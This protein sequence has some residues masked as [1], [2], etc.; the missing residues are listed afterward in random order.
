MPIE[1]ILTAWK[2]AIW[3]IWENIWEWIEFVWEKVLDAADTV[4][5]KFT[6]VKQDFVNLLTTWPKKKWTPTKITDEDSEY[7]NRI[8]NNS[9]TQDVKEIWW[10]LL[11]IWFWKTKDALW[12][13][14][15]K[16]KSWIKM[17]D[18]RSQIDSKYWSMWDLQKKYQSYLDSI[19]KDARYALLNEFYSKVDSL[20]TSWMWDAEAVVTTQSM[21]SQKEL[22]E[23]SKQQKL[24]E[25]TA[26]PEIQK[27]E[28]NIKDSESSLREYVWNTIEVEEWEDPLE[29][30][31]WW[32]E[33]KFK[34]TLW[35][36]QDL[37]KKISEEVDLELSSRLKVWEWADWKI[38]LAKTDKIKEL[39]VDM[40]LQRLNALAETKEE[41]RDTIN[42]EYKKSNEVMK[43][44][45]LTQLEEEQKI[46]D[47][48]K[49]AFLDKD[50][51][52][53][54]RDAAF[55]AFYKLSEEEQ[56]IL[57][58]RK[59]FNWLMSTRVE[60]TQL[61]KSFW[62]FESSGW[63]WLRQAMDTMQVL[64]WASWIL[65]N[66]SAEWF[67][68]LTW[69]SDNLIINQLANPIVNADN[70]ILTKI[71]KYVTYN[72]WDL[73]NTMASTIAPNK[74]I[75]AATKWTTKL[76]Q[77]SLASLPNLNKATA[78]Q[79]MINWKK[80]TFMLNAAKFYGTSVATWVWPNKAIDDSLWQ[81]WTESNEQFNILTDM[82]FDSTLWVAWKWTS[83]VYTKWK[84]FVK[85]WYAESTNSYMY[86]F[87][88]GTNKEAR[89]KAVASLTEHF[90]TRKLQDWTVW[91]KI[92]W[93]PATT[94]NVWEFLRNEIIPLY[95]Q[96]VDPY[97][98]NKIF[99]KWEFVEF[100]SDHLKDLTNTWNE[101]LLTEKWIWIELVDEFRD[102]SNKLKD[103]HILA[104]N[105][106]LSSNDATK[107]FYKSALYSQLDDNLKRIEWSSFKSKIWLWTLEKVKPEDLIKYKSIIEA[108]KT[109]KP[110]TI[111]M[112]IDEYIEQTQKINELYA[113]EKYQKWIRLTD[114]ITWNWVFIKMSDFEKIKEM[115]WMSMQEM[116]KNWFIEITQDISTKTWIQQ[117]L[118]ITKQEINWYWFIKKNTRDN[119]RQAQDFAK[120]I[121]SENEVNE[122]ALQLATLIRAT[123]LWGW[124]MQWLIATPLDKFVDYDK[125]IWF[126]FER[127]QDVYWKNLI[128]ELNLWDTNIWPSWVLKAVTETDS[129]FVFAHWKIQSKDWKVINVPMYVLPWKKF[130]D[131]T[132]LYSMLE[133]IWDNIDAGR[134]SMYVEKASKI[135]REVLV[136][137][138][139][140]DWVIDIKW[141]IEKVDVLNSI[142]W[143]YYSEQWVFNMDRVKLTINKA[144]DNHNNLN[145]WNQFKNNWDIVKTIW[146]FIKH[147]D[148]DSD[149]ILDVIIKNIT[150]K[151]IANPNASKTLEKFL[152]SSLTLEK[153][154]NFMK[155]FFLSDDLISKLSSKKI[156]VD[157]DLLI[158]LVKSDK[159]K[160]IKRLQISK[161][162]LD[163]DIYAIKY[164][165][166]DMR[167]WNWDILKLRADLK[168][169]EDRLK[170]I[171]KKL[172]ITDEEYIKW[173][174]WIFR[175][176]KILNKL[177]GIAWN[178]ANKIDDDLAKY[179]DKITS[180]KDE[181]KEVKKIER[182]FKKLSDKQKLESNKILDQISKAKSKDDLKIIIKEL[183]E[184]KVDN[185]IK[186][187]VN[188]KIKLMDNIK[189][190]S[191]FRVDILKQV[192]DYAN[193]TMWVYDLNKLTWKSNPL[194]AAF[195]W[196]WAAK[197]NETWELT[198]MPLMLLESFKK[199]CWVW[200]EV[201][202]ISD[203]IDNE[204]FKSFTENFFIRKADVVW[205]W[206]FNTAYTKRHNEIKKVLKE[207]LWDAFNNIQW[208][209]DW[210][211]VN[212]ANDIIEDM[213][214]WN[215]FKKLFN[216]IKW[217]ANRIKYEMPVLKLDKNNNVIQSYWI[218]QDRVIRIDEM[219]K[220]MPDVSFI[221]I[222][223]DSPAKVISNISIS[224][225]AKPKTFKTIVKKL[226]KEDYLTDDDVLKVAINILNDAWWELEE[227]IIKSN[228]WIKQSLNNVIWLKEWQKIVWSFWDK[229]NY[230]QVWNVPEWAIKNNDITQMLY[231]AYYGLTMWYKNSNKIIRDMKWELFSFNDLIKW[232]KELW[233]TLTTKEDFKSA[234]SK[235]KVWWKIIK[236]WEEVDAVVTDYLIQFDKI[237]KRESSWTS[238][239]Y[240][241]DDLDIKLRAYILKP[242]IDRSNWIFDLLEEY[243]KPIT[244]NYRKIQIITELRKA[245]QS[246][247]NISKFVKEEYIEWDYL[248]DSKIIWFLSQMYKDNFD[249]WAAVTKDLHDKR[250]LANWIEPWLYR[251]FKDHIKD[252]TKDNEEFFIKADFHWEKAIL[253]WAELKNS[254]FTTSE[255]LKLSWW[256]KPVSDLKLKSNIITIWWR[257]FEIE[258][259]QD[260]STRAFKDAAQE[261][262]DHT[263]EVTTAWN[264]AYNSLP[265]EYQRDLAIEIN[266]EIDDLWNKLVLDKLWKQEF[267]NTR[268]KSDIDLEVENIVSLYK[269][270]WIEQVWTFSDALLQWYVW[271]FL[272]ASTHL[273]NKNELDWVKNIIKY[274][275]E[276]LWLNEIKISSNDKLID[277]AIWEKQA[278][279]DLL[280]TM[281]QTKDILSEIKSLTKEDWVT[282][283]TDNLFILWLRHPVPS[284]Y[285][286]WVYKI[287]KDDNLVEWTLVTNPFNTYLKVEWD[288]DWDTLVMSSVYSNRWYIMWK[289]AIDPS[290]EY[291]TKPRWDFYS[292]LKSW[293]DNQYIVVSQ[294]DDIVDK[295]KKELSLLENRQVALA[296]K[297]NIGIVQ[298]FWRSL[299]LFMEYT[300]SSEL[301]KKSFTV[302]FDWK[303][304]SLFDLYNLYKIELT[305]ELSKKFDELL[306]SKIQVTLDFA[307][308][309]KSEF[310]KWWRK[311]I[312]ELVLWNQLKTLDDEWRKEL[313]D[314]FI[315]DV[316]EPLSMT[317][318][319]ND[320]IK[321]FDFLNT[322]DK[323]SMYYKNKIWIKWSAYKHIMDTYWDRI[324]TF[325]MNS[326]KDFIATFKWETK[327]VD[328]IFRLVW[329]SVSKKATEWKIDFRNAINAIW[330]L[331][332]DKYKKLF[333]LIDIA[334]D[335]LKELWDNEKYKAFENLDIDNLSRDERLL[336]S[337]Y[338]IDNKSY[339]IFNLLT[340]EEKLTHIEFAAWWKVD[341]LLKR[342]KDWREYKAIQEYKNKYAELINDKKWVKIQD[343]LSDLEELKKNYAT[344][345]KSSDSYTLDHVKIEEEIAK[346][347]KLV[348]DYNSYKENISNLIESSKQQ[349]ELKEKIN[350]EVTEQI[351]EIDWW[352][353]FDE[354]SM[355]N[356][357]NVAN[358]YK[359]ARDKTMQLSINEILAK[360]DLRLLQRLNFLT[361]QSKNVEYDWLIL[362]RANKDFWIRF[363]KLAKNI[364]FRWDQLDKLLKDIHWAF[365]EEIRLIDWK[366][367]ISDI[368]KVIKKIQDAS[369]NK[370]WTVIADILSNDDFRTLISEFKSSFIDKALYW[371]N[372]VISKTKWSRNEI[373]IENYLKKGTNTLFNDFVESLKNDYTFW[374]RTLNIM[375]KTDAMT[376]LMN[377]WMWERNASILSN[378]LYPPRI[379][380]VE[381]TIW[382]I[383]AL[384]YMMRYW[385]VWTTAMIW[386]L[387]WIAQLLPNYYQ[388]VWFVDIHWDNLKKADNIITK[389]WILNS[390]DTITHSLWYDT[391]TAASFIMDRVWSIFRKVWELATWWNIKAW[392]AVEAFIM[393]PLSF[394]DA[395]LD[396]IRKQAALID[397]LNKKWIPLDHSWFKQYLEERVSRWH[398]LQDVINDIS[399]EARDQY[400]KSWG[401]VI[402]WSQLYRKTLL[403][404]MNI[405]WDEEKNILARAV[406]WMVWYLNWW[407]F[408]NTAVLIYKY[409]SLWSWLTSLLKWDYK[410]SWLLVWDWLMY[411]KWLL[412][413]S[414]NAIW[415]FLKFE[416]YERDHE[417]IPTKQEFVNDFNN[418]L[419]SLEILMW[420]IFDDVELANKYWDEWTDWFKYSTLNLIKRYIR[421]IW[422]M[423]KLA[424][425][426]YDQYIISMEPDSSAMDKM[427]WLLTAIRDSTK[428]LNDTF[429]RFNWLE[430][431]KD[432]YDSYSSNANIWLLWLWGAT[433]EDKIYEFNMKWKNFAYFE[434]EWFAQSLLKYLQTWISPW[435]YWDTYATKKEAREILVD[436]Y[437]SE[438]WKLLTNKWISKDWSNWTYDIRNILWFDESITDDNAYAIQ[439]I[440][441]AMIYDRSDELDSKWRNI[442]NKIWDNWKKF[443][444]VKIDDIITDN[445]RRIAEE[446]WID[447][448][449]ILQEKNWNSK[450][451]QKLLALVEY[452]WEW[453]APQLI[454]YLVKSRVDEYSK[455]YKE[456]SWLRTEFWYKDLPEY[457]DNLAW[458]NSLIDYADL[459]NTDA[460]LVNKVFE[461]E[462][463]NNNKDIYSRFEKTWRTEK[464]INEVNRLAANQYIATRNLQRWDTSVWALVSKWAVTFKWFPEDSQTA[465]NIMIDTLQMIENSDQD[466]KTKVAKQAAAILWISEANYKLVQDNK[467]FESLSY[468]SKKTI[469]NWLYKISD[470]A[471]DYDSNKLTKELNWAAYWKSQY[472]KTPYIKKD[473][474]EQRPNFSKQ[475]APIEKLAQ[476]YRNYKSPDYRNMIAQQMRTTSQVVLNH[477]AIPYV[478]EVQ[479]YKSELFMNELVSKG[480][481][482]GL[483]QQLPVAKP[484]K[485]NIIEK[486][487]RKVKNPKQYLPPVKSKERVWLLRNRPFF[488]E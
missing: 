166:N 161:E 308:S 84:W 328:D 406:M 210:V 16:I 274:S 385:I 152:D 322:K 90:N 203:L 96:T 147:F 213:L 222:S 50:Y 165:I 459:L 437:K 367:D 402:S 130:F 401:W 225:W 134:F 82:F 79:S 386:Q 190:P 70:W 400:A 186:D 423:P 208:I 264:Q 105:M 331:D 232:L 29:K 356:L 292:M 174:I 28:K 136:E 245:A 236:D 248:D 487:K 65:L 220:E 396:N 205:E 383:N 460:T 144:I 6:D 145:Q 283:D 146:K 12:F 440:K 85:S 188:L 414:M 132:W 5:D 478:K 344:E 243:K 133:D 453:K 340:A 281:E 109:S 154:F 334:K 431:I 107:K 323:L 202:S 269:A 286:L 300:K 407:A 168:K 69:D 391:D 436:L 411:H 110:D 362:A 474:W 48:D 64:V 239:I 58:D 244:D 214:T 451:L 424:T 216:M 20:K 435:L 33:K 419:V 206:S 480:V 299:R 185:N 434:S 129:Y 420:Q 218:Y 275:D 354:A 306:A 363:Q 215:N 352:L 224:T 285:N 131:N 219:L 377:T 66:K 463:K 350:I 73:L 355:L 473:Y 24:Y 393:S 353:V 304:K 113:K 103:T 71:W 237:S 317:Y 238:W 246:D 394:F 484:I 111:H 251:P 253:D 56:E 462:F 155:D 167:V 320:D 428:E 223:D 34:W 433:T 198:W 339:K 343:L 15:I 333:N 40:E 458:K 77:M 432:S 204:K 141:W 125:E 481:I 221:R 315:N 139:V 233:W 91:L 256:F 106:L 102:L 467:R 409:W 118:L 27:Y 446:Q 337:I 470:T 86:D 368:S 405:Y 92:N 404:S 182:K 429:M 258:S 271:D 456:E 22:S 387:M 80:A 7:I 178:M 116:L 135:I 123:S 75:W 380:K 234:L 26:L 179:T 311:E 443:W 99:N 476:D 235:I 326:D 288:H 438:A 35:I 32:T 25:T 282:L 148:K 120:K 127:L 61:W 301:Y 330:K 1:D 162:I 369:T 193:S 3:N 95:K 196:I 450:W 270:A 486:A 349:L 59:L 47:R 472:F 68:D 452:W 422:A 45:Y 278:R 408:K 87:M 158:R 254:V 183:N 268:F 100:I 390:E 187:Y 382:F 457:Y 55:N 60:A 197:A 289:S 312:I 43:K 448:D 30:L 272:N 76:A 112:K 403:S 296:A 297:W 38:L 465:A 449:T 336:L 361:E 416:K 468:D 247:P 441:D 319:N 176:E 295:S 466:P 388:I 74:V 348:Y 327:E 347:Q 309:W 372:D 41:D 287:V 303:E 10:M 14:D 240:T 392:K 211:Q 381:K 338:A 482:K 121:V 373:N 122:K 280:K 412:N 83:N 346:M 52:K 341:K 175:N 444:T 108:V 119:Y 78:I 464:V 17:E 150:Y 485:R 37:N 46:R 277:I 291:Y 209:K 249:W 395:P 284:R 231:W 19:E 54:E 124:K 351:P 49:E 18:F 171:N 359:A 63:F 89:E 342:L 425:T 410:R 360:Y 172:S 379:Q 262:N 81:I 376:H 324:N 194:I 413:I 13:W 261:S 115:N 101:K 316:I 294:V 313:I 9:W 53:W 447:I 305:P 94:K 375:N 257:Q 259:Y 228:P 104:K 345:I 207:V 273:I 137:S 163:N 454:N 426:I 427:T 335:R 318:K 191:D 265:F 469:V 117:W 153:K 227:S 199:Y 415:L 325:V 442:S 201:R 290:T 97:I 4:S 229:S 138:K 471:Y 430:V 365:N 445:M 114:S 192:K 310:E 36:S 371:I 128:K 241:F 276:T 302:W 173:N 88:F 461:I 72:P 51:S 21:Y 181:L 358:I 329:E 177:N 357:A 314:N 267:D 226:F 44:F 23:I 250:S 399:T 160:F 149:E 293:Y 98:N 2:E 39:F 230:L 143:W 418:S 180:L 439:K 279:L 374:L 242:V 212:V 57:K 184:S 164:S 31:M 189:D 195:R 421:T 321:M 370:D 389:Y 455:I 364:W 255:S 156:S 252:R 142:T 151:L 159:E 260:I 200:D 93:Q 266:K 8:K 263:K 366:Y 398:H 384:H 67:A 417:D 217:T 170:D 475:F 477:F 62:N 483:N 140:V 479:Q 298:S 157:E 11:W 332:K 378:I 397:T 42:W 307:K 126:I 169:L 488:Y